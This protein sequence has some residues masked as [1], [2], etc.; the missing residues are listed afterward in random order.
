[1]GWPP[2]GCPATTSSLCW[3]WDPWQGD[4][5]LCPQPCLVLGLGKSLQQSLLQA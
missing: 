5:R 1:M 3:G 4:A 2:R